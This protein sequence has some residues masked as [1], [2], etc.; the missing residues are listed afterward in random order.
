MVGLHA[1]EIPGSASK[2]TWQQTVGSAPL[3]YASD[4]FYFR[5]KWS[6]YQVHGR[7]FSGWFGEVS[8]FRVRGISRVQRESGYQ[9]RLRA[10]RTRTRWR[11]PMGKFT[12]LGVAA[13]LSTAIATPV[14]AQAVIQEPGAY[15]FSYPNGD[16]GI[17]SGTSQRGSETTT[18]PWPPPAAHR[19]PRAADVPASAFAS[20]QIFHQEDE[21]VD[22]V[23]GSVCRGC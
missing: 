7:R 23:I 19:Q 9:K 17:G 5:T 18:R 20:Q 10:T 1:S 3:Q 21:K 15:A 16:L 13:I 22:R 11:R 14:L 6:P 8:I 2:F 12:F 4:T